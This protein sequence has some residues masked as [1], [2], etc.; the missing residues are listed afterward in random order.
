MNIK[1][2]VQEIQEQV[3]QWRHQIHSNPELGYHEYQTAALVEKVL[4]EAGIKVTRYP[5]STA[6]LGVLEGGKPGRTIALRADMDAL[7]IQELADVPYRSKNDGVMHAC[8]HD[9]H[10]AVLLGAASVLAKYREE[11]PGTVKFLFQPAEEVPPGGAK[12]M[13]ADGVLKNPDA[14]Y[15]FGLHATV[16]QPTGSIELLSGYSHANTDGCTITVIGKGAHGAYPHNGVDAVH[17]AGHII[18]GLH[19]IVSRTL[20]PLDS[21]VITVGSV[22]AGT[23]NNIIAETAEMK[24]TVRSLL[25]ETRETLKERIITVAEHTA[26]AHGAK[27][28]VDYWYGY[29]SVYN[30]DEAIAIVERAAKTLLPKENIYY[31]SKPGMGGEDFAYFANE[32]PGAFF[33]LGE[34]TPGD[35]YPGHNPRYNASDDGLVTGV[36]MMVGIVFEAS[37]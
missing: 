22:H 9:T 15:V 20:D 11:I 19:S 13:V 21:G 34:K 4:T 17:V 29:P 12:A 32:I 8:G 28:I 3:I 36:E 5:D 37:K 27:A 33:Y 14:E 26:A 18:V 7:P 30:S 35:N 24:L 31:R 6:V 10:T 25:K 2:A 16:S 1:N 23:V